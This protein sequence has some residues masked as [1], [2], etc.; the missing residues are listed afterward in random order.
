[1]TD[2]LPITYDNIDALAASAFAKSRIAATAIREDV[3]HNLKPLK[4]TGS[5]RL[6]HQIERRRIFDTE[7]LDEIDVLADLV[8]RLIQ[9][10]TT[11]IECIDNDECNVSPGVWTERRRTRAADE[12]GRA[13]IVL[14]DL[15]ET[16]YA[17]HD[18]MHAERAI[19]ALRM[20]S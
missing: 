5:E 6:L 3:L 14:Y 2:L 7:M 17:V 9:E 16:L 19:E 13:L 20:A 12:L 18:L 8:T 15:Q 1:M 11:V 4:R 10:G